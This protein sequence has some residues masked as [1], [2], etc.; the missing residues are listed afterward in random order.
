[1]SD[2]AD[3]ART[4]WEEHY[5]AKPQVWSGRVNAQLAGVVAEL[6]PGRALDLGCG[7]GADAI[8][9]AEQGWT[10][11]AVDVSTI[12][13]GRARVEAERRNVLGW[14]IFHAQD[15]ESPVPA[16]PYDLVSAQF[17]HSTVP[18][19]R[20][21]ILR[22]VAAEVAPG[23]SLLIVDHAA[24][25]PWASKLAH[26]RFPGIEEVLGGLDLD[27]AEWERVRVQTLQRPVVGPDGEPAVLDD[28][29]IWLR[30]VA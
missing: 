27:D 10:V 21:A 7:E 30:K 24:T 13:L 5:R 19:D 22:R 12:A 17:L 16:G 14:I 9:L 8:W 28:N 2:Q 3:D 25:P 23:G 15:L 26:H 6:T 29:V 4:V 11:T 18:M 20:P 1:M